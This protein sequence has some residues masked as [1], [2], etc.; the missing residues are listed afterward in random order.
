MERTSSSASAERQL[1][2]WRASVAS[3]R[4]G[5][6][7][8]DEDATF[9]SRADTACMTRVCVGG[10]LYR[11]GQILLGLRSATLSFY[12]AKWD[13]IGGHREAGETIEAT[14]VREF[15]E[16]LAVTPLEWECLGV[17]AEPDSTR[18][19]PGEYHVFVVRKWARE[20]RNASPEHDQIAWVDVHELAALDLA[21][22]AYV[23]IF[24]ALR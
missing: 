5:A 21:A 13:I 12:P 3:G 24:G 9:Q 11:D 14:L 8:H 16:E 6:V 23:E 7:S 20:P 19:G 10:V 4:L 15:E 1:A 17:F 22:D 2:A 18:H